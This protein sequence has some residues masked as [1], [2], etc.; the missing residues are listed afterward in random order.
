[1]ESLLDQADELVAAA[2]ESSS[3]A[4]MPRP[5]FAIP[6]EYAA[7]TAA[8]LQSNANS[9]MKLSKSLV[10]SRGGG[11]GWIAAS[12]LTAGTV[13]LTAKPIA[14]IMDWQN[15]ENDDDADEEEEDDEEDEGGN[16]KMKEV[17]KE[18]RLN[19]LLLLE[20]LSKL[21]KDPLLWTEQLSTLFPRN[22]A[23]LAALP[24]WVC[25]NDDVFMQVE[26][27][28]S[29]LEQ[30]QAQHRLPIEEIAKRLPLILRYNILSMETCAELLSYPGQGG[31]A[32][33]AG[34]ALYHAP[35]FFNHSAR[36][37]VSRWCVG[38]VMVFVT[39]QNVPAGSEL[40]LS[41]LE[42]D[43]LCEPAW[44]RNR[45]LGMDFNDSDDDDNITTNGATDNGHGDNSSSM[46]TEERGNEHHKGPDMP[47]VDSD[48]Q[49]ELM[50]MDPFARLVAID[51]LMAQAI[52]YKRPTEHTTNKKDMNLDNLIVD[53]NNTS[54][55]NNSAG[56][57][58]TSTTRVN[59]PNVATGNNNNNSDT[60]G[61]DN[62]V[63]WFQCDVHN[64]CILKAITLD[65]LG[66]TAEALVLWEE[67]VRFVE[68]RLP[69]LDES[70][71]V[72][73]AQAALCAWHII[74]P[75]DD[76]DGNDNNTNSESVARRHAAVAL[77]THILLFGG[78]VAR[79]RRRLQRDLQ[80]AL[81]P[82]SALRNDANAMTDPVD[83][84]W[85]LEC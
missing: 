52:G 66:Q 5:D 77:E 13:L 30:D 31:H 58:E 50:S 37:T 14:Y 7:T 12:N 46:M 28:L 2:A 75:N 70:V 85:P 56:I 71:I 82:S 79:F 29:A 69:P 41:Y 24:A 65:G 47:V 51:E 83:E 45:M 61:D 22:E 19:E 20:I 21:Q 38:D 57:M 33:L 42:H 16:T 18:P 54:A 35:S 11:W 3:A 73:R 62:A 60:N 67:S 4:S 74:P 8:A 36:P 17:L 55:F 43:V 53:E 27:L 59:Q 10:A 15:D 23:D 25:H 40:C 78:G 49:N 80:L 34:V 64:L 81:R 9:V 76:D 1:M 68:Q 39:N 63:P 72:L 48:V 32:P 26:S 44:R 84:L 6:D